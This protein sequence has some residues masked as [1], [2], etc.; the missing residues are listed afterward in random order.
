MLDNVITDDLR[1]LPARAAQLIRRYPV[2]LRGIYAPE[3]RISILDAL[4]HCAAVRG[5]AFVAFQLLSRIELPGEH[6][7]HDDA[8]HTALESLTQL[9]VT[10]DECAH[11]F[12]PNWRPVVRYAVEVADMLHGNFHSLTRTDS[13]I[14]NY[15]RLS[16][17][18]A[19]R[20]VAWEAGRINSW[21]RAQDAAWEREYMDDVTA[22]LDARACA[23]TAAAVRD[24]A[25]AIAL[26]DL[27]GTGDFSRAH[28]ETL[29]APWYR[30]LDNMEATSRKTSQSHLAASVDT[31]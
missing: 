13:L 6:C 27:I 23:D 7:L 16:A 20:D 19:A 22:R 10:E 31:A 9:E 17:W 8:V 18:I 24:A 3:L 28:Y 1:L 21:Y 4:V 29:I 14:G 2:P 5:E 25:A 11:A 26:S 12:G 30:V 15:R